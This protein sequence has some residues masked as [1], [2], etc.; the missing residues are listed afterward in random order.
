[1]S[2]GFNRRALLRTGVVAFLAAI[3]LAAIP[4]S[5]F[6]YTTYVS[7]DF[8]A[9]RAFWISFG[10]KAGAKYDVEYRDGPDAT[11]WTR[12]KTLTREQG[13]YFTGREGHTYWFRVRYR[14]P[15]SD[16]ALFSVVVPYD[17]TGL[18]YLTGGWYS[19]GTAAYQA[20]ARTV[21]Y[22]TRRGATARM[23]FTG[24]TA[25]IVAPRRAAEARWT[26]T[27]MGSRSRTG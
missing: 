18:R 4:A 24:R 15:T 27:S 11:N 8:S 10:S 1:M 7:T 22:T 17:N 20:Y 6:A 16:W 2:G 23:T 21:K 9:T 12:W 5:A 3:I 26:S 19:G 25:V 13:A 14:M